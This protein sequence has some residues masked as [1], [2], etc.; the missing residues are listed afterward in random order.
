MYSDIKD[1]ISKELLMKYVKDLRKWNKQTTMK[2]LMRIKKKK[3][4]KK[5]FVLELP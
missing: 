4:G 3:R 2:R 1:F 5:Q